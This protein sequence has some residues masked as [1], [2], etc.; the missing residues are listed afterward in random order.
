MIS[1]LRKQSFLIFLIL[2]SSFLRL[3]G[4]GYSN[5]YGDETKTLYL[6]KT[7]PALSF[8]MNQRKGPVQF[9]MVWIMEKLSGGYSEF[10]VRLPFALASIL[11]VVVFYFLVKRLFNSQV[12]YVSSLLLS[13]NGLSIAFGRTA[14]YQS[15]LL[16]F[17][18]SSLYLLSL[19]FGNIKKKYLLI[20]AFFFLALAV[21][22]HYDG[23]FYLVPFI[24]II[25]SNREEIGKDKKFVWWALPG[26]L[27]F[28]AIISIFYL[29][30]YS[31]G[32]FTTNSA[33]YLSRRVFGSGYSPNNS[34]YAAKIYN[35]FFIPFIFMFLSLFGVVGQPNWKKVMLILWFAVPFIV[36]EFIFLNPGT[37]IFNYYLPLFV[38][39]G[40]GIVWLYD[41]FKETRSKRSFSV[42]IVFLFILNTLIVIFTYVPKFN[43]GYP[44][45][46]F[47]PNKAYH[48]YLYGFPYNRAWKEIGTYLKFK[49]ARNFYTN[50]NIT[51]AEYYLYGIPPTQ[52]VISDQQYPQYYI[53]V[54]NNQEFN[55]EKD[56]LPSFY[57]LDKDFYSEGRV[58]ARVFRLMIQKPVNY[59]L[60]F[61]G[62]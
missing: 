33:G 18:L 57:V 19:F 27:L 54:Y 10:F 39:S 12:A 22:C 21:L 50:D 46:I 31:N 5:F 48:L 37:H 14:Q 58:V 56:K 23:I 61:S 17:G 52:L 34:L 29:P 16:L 8:F 20:F 43:F 38:L 62:F 42:L 41:Y 47:R 36:F 4:L 13:I 53:Y 11:A 55:N 3:S 40:V 15:F 30:Y 49:G 51:V 45:K 28:L 2:L 60:T 59:K 7:I 1:I 24:V 32:S 25:I 6:N 44:W 9:L 35:P 26:L